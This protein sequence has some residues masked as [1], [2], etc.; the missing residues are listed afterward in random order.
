MESTRGAATGKVSLAGTPLRGGSITLVAKGN[1][2]L[3]VTTMIRSDG[4]FSVSNAPLGPVQIGV[5]TESLKMGAPPEDYIAI[6]RR[7]ANPET[8]ELTATVEPSG[9]PLVIEL[10]E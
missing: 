8:S 9:E 6:P 4:T 2:D 7:Y 5:E 3:R 1:S 10:T